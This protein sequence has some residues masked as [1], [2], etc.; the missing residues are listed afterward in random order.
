MQEESLLSES[1]EKPR[2]MKRPSD[3][4]SRGDNVKGEGGRE[5]KDKEKGRG[6]REKE[7]GKVDVL[8]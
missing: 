3:S 8:E 6:R 5:R 2:E 7:S 4:N 1:P